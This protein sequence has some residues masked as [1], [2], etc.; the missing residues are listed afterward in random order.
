[1]KEQCDGGMKANRCPK[2]VYMV[3]FF[4]YQDPKEDGGSEMDR[5]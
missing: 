5:I 4:I 3:A 2:H 1:M